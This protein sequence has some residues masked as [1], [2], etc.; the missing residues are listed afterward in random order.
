MSVEGSFHSGK[1]ERRAMAIASNVKPMLQYIS[2]GS[3]RSAV[4]RNFW[5]M[6]LSDNPRSAGLT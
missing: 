5:R 3:C 1:Y 2:S 4:A 6:K